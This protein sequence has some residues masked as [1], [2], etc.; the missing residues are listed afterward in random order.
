MDDRSTPVCYKQHSPPHAD[1]NIIY[2]GRIT[3]TRER[4]RERERENQLWYF[5]ASNVNSLT[6]VMV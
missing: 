1:T 2:T 6:L 3:R 4:E 5:L